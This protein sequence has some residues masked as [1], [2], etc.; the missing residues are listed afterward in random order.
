MKKY[1]KK[2]FYDNFDKGRVPIVPDDINLKSIKLKVVAVDDVDVEVYLSQTRTADDVMA[3][4]MDLNSSFASGIDWEE[5]LPII[6]KRR[7]GSLSLVDAFGRFEMFELNN[8]EYWLM[9]QVE[10]DDNNE[11]L[12]RGWANRKKYRKPSDIKDN[13]ELISTAVRKGFIKPSEYNFRKY[14]NTIEPHKGKEEKAEIIQTLVDKFSSKIKP[15][16]KRFVSYTAATMNKRWVSKHFADAKRLGFKL[17]PKGKPK[18]SK[19]SDCYFGIV[20]KGYESRKILQAI[21]FNLK[22]DCPMNV[23]GLSD[24][25]ITSKKKLK[26]DRT[27]ISRNLTKLTNRLDAIYEKYNG[28]VKWKEVINL[29]GFIPEDVNEDVKEPVDYD[30]I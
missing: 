29:F 24:G 11:L 17:G 2:F 14:L 13:V 19:K 10:C 28:N 23:L 5:P 1:N 16:A 21:E 6:K 15:K 12:L 25:K 8:Q 18:Y 7:D 3:R 26:N 22:K 9:A 30:R 27:T 20:Q 4:A